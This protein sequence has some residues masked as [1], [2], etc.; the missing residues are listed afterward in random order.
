VPTRK[1]WR[2]L[3]HDETAARRLA[4]AIDTNEVVA[5]L[6]L[7]RGVSDPAAAALFL[8]SPMSGLHSPD[9]LPNVAAAVDRLTAAIS[10]GQKVCVYGDYDVDGTT[11]TA[12]L[13][14]LLGKLGG[15]VVFHIP[16]RL[17]DGYGLNADPLRKLA[18]EGVKVVVTVDCGITAVAEADLAR[19]LGI[20][21]IVTDH[22][23][24]KATL[25][26]ATLVHPRLP[27]SAYPF[28][29]ISGS[30]VAFK[31]AWAVAQKA[32]G[33]SRV[34]EELREFLLDAMGL[35]ALGVV[36]DVVPL[37][38]ENR[39]FTRH[40]LKRLVRRPSIGLKALFDEAKL[41]DKLTAE[42]VS[43]K[44]G[45]RINAAGRLGCAR[46]VV[47]L[48]T[49]TNPR[50][51]AEIAAFLEGQNGQ[52][53]TIER[54]ATAQAK[55]MVEQNGWADAPAIVIGHAAA[56]WH[57]GVVGIVAGRLVEHYGKPALVIALKDD[58]QPSSGSGRSVKGFELHTALDACTDLLEGHGGHAAAVGLRVKPS[59][60]DA[61]RE[62]FCEY[63]TRTF[64]DGPPPPTLLLDAELPLASLSF[65]L[66]GD[67]DKLEPYGQ[68]NPR[69]RFL[70]T[71]VQIEGT[72]RRIG[73]GERHLSF[74]V[75]Q[76]GTTMRAVAW[77]MG[78][79]LDEIMSDG[80]RCCLAFTPKINEWNNHRSVEIEVS[81]FQ[82]KR[83][84]DLS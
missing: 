45:P 26:A 29:G 38:D 41:T 32:N 80:G 59:N 8:Q 1:Q 2:L 5:Q 66:L 21:L 9:L 77:G 73:Q 76:G 22:H 69:P 4:A 46:L 70:A 11:G 36:A 79:R 13:F 30:C 55:E 40:G 23:E 64:P 15:N 53:Q 47:E 81:D 10:A 19:E 6:L 35:A 18:E 54:K 71:D 37:R 83:L 25:P 84:A 75:R 7:N 67:I 57:Q 20:D 39:V 56:E 42:D 17:E 62:R 74:R 24:M 16:V 65:K 52:R 3:P 27:G 72:P 44:I 34:S 28:G 51:A 12:I 60:L 58:D 82:P 48:L 33:G 78:D 63:V 61:L 50:K 68:D 14:A 43:F 49:T 31:L